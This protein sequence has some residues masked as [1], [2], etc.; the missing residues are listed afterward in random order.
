MKSTDT[1]NSYLIAGAREYPDVAIV[2]VVRSFVV[3]GVKMRRA[4]TVLLDETATVI[5]PRGDEFTAPFSEELRTIVE[6]A[7]T[8]A[9]GER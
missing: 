2:T 9:G 5:D 8:A 1:S 7:T 6:M 4:F 3:A